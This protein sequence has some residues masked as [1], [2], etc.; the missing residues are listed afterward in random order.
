[1]NI[2]FGYP[3]Q[4][5]KECQKCELKVDAYYQQRGPVKLMLVG[6]DPT[7]FK[8]KNRVK[9]VL[10]LDDINGQ[11]S[12]WLRN[13]FGNELFNDLTIYATNLVKCTL[14]NPPSTMPGG[15][16]NFLREYY[17]NCKK[18]L[19]EEIKKFQPKILLTLGEPS[20]ILFR[21]ILDDPSLIPITMQGSFSGIF[22]RV[23]VK[24]VKFDYSPCLH[25]KTFRVAEVYGESVKTF[26]KEILNYFNINELHS[27]TN[28]LSAEQCERIPETGIHKP[29]NKWR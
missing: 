7:I 18:Y 19:E 23:S 22:T 26:K 15:G 5:C 16:L 1:M 14:E 10:M 12:R 8:D 3:S 27:S 28:K 13:L 2:T 6:Q 20:H 9:H 4:D 17:A 24:E 21:T 25:I 11:L 29:C